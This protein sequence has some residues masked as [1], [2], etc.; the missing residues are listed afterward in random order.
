MSKEGGAIVDRGVV[1]V[2]GTLARRVSENGVVRLGIVSRRAR[3]V[4][5]SSWLEGRL[6]SDAIRCILHSLPSR[7]LLPR[8]LA[9]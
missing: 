6:S 7:K 8:A 5:E 4:L 2:A 3:P 9:A 1:D